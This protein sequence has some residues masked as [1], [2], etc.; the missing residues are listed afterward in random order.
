MRR[1]AHVVLAVVAVL[2]GLCGPAAVAAPA[3]CV[4]SGTQAAINKALV[5]AGKKVFL[6][7]GAVFKLSAPVKFTAPRQELATKGLP[8]GS[9]RATLRL[10]AA[11]ITTAVD[12]NGQ[13]GIVLQNVQVDGNRAALG[14]KAGNALV[15]LG[16]NVADQV[17]R[18]SLIREPRSWSAL[19]LFEG[20]VTSSVP[21]CQRAQV[22]DNE[23]GPAGLD[24][25]SGQWADGISLA[26]GSSTVRGNTIT[27]AT[28][29]GI[30]VFGA[31]G[32]VI[33]QNTIVAV[34]RVLLGGI[35]MVD[36][37][38]VN[39][40]YTGTIVRNNVI[41]AR[42]AFVK[43]GLAQGWQV[44]TCGTGTVYGGT[45]TGNTLRGQHLG[46]GYAVNG[47]RDWTVSGNVDQARHVGVPSAGC[48]GLP[49][50]PA[51]YQVA[52]ATSSTLQ[53][54]FQPA[55][56]TYVLGVTEPTP[57]PTGT[58]PALCRWI[59]PGEAVFTGATARSCD[60]R[61]HL[62]LQNDGN[63]VLTFG[64]SNQVLWSANTAGQPSAL[65]LMQADGNF[66]LYGTSG[67]VLW[68]TNTAGNPGAIL[69]IQDD[70]NLVLFASN[71]VT[72]LWSTNTGGH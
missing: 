24:S 57:P 61:T 68:S 30:V 6:C 54:E 58:P 29:G 8:T 48:G 19:H 32:S 14:R 16:G 72:K 35:S 46:Y 67:Q 13:S 45:V 47:V 52:A 21:G 22:V 69:V 71:G 5:G 39:G 42:S 26:C 9:T 49:S 3:S 11:G 51:G 33:E 50:A 34:S 41:E 23:I 62:T 10:N 27:D 53:S 36:V 18:K 28:D 1:R 64:P 7:A 56:L 38:P 37:A 12:G 40:N 70:G 25:P 59:R 2:V 44:W 31:P 65:A 4:P 66:V 15:Q 17:V 60:G 63:L 55:S 43:V 20:T